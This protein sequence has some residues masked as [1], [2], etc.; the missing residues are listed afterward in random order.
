MVKDIQRHLKLVL[1]PSEWSKISY[2]IPYVVF[3]KKD[4]PVLVYVGVEHTIDPGNSQITF[5]RERFEKFVAEYP[6]CLMGIE[7]NIPSPEETVELSI[8]KYGERGLLASLA[9]WHACTTLP[10]LAPYPEILRRL[11]KDFGEIN[12]AL[13]LSLNILYH[14]GK[15]LEKF[16]E[17][18]E[19][20]TRDRIS[21]ILR[22]FQV[23]DFSILADLSKE[24]TGQDV[25][26]KNLNAVFEENSSLNFEII[27]KLQSPYT[28]ETVLNK[29][30]SQMNLLQDQEIVSLLLSHLERGERIFAV[31]GHNHVVAQ[32]PALRAFFAEKEKG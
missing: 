3:L 5:V 4:P 11:K 20:Q 27:K 12:V 13:L 28:S 31:M 8:K 30:S 29:I 22:D 24:I 10:L 18:G 32:E 1:T 7:H 23:K 6:D 21:S 25:L 16:T 19:K 9:E 2:P 14:M 17:D 15:N 26:P